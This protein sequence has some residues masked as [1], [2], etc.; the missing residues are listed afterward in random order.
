MIGQAVPRREDLPLIRG[1]GQYVDDLD[2]PGLALVA[3]V[4]SHHARARIADI[5]LPDRAP[6]LLR[7]LSA[8]DLVGRAGP[9]PVAAPD[10]VQVENVPHPILAAKEVRYVG[11]PV[12]AVVA[13][14]R[15]Q[16][17]DAAERVEIEYDELEAVVEGDGPV[18]QAAGTLRWHRNAEGNRS[19]R[20]S[21]R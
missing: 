9:L 14:S 21:R 5:R 16:A 13:E 8:V 6:G 3:F 15:A 1:Q 19:R 12:V 11:Q 4:R 18:R 2:H 10:G 20:M 7:V 17:V